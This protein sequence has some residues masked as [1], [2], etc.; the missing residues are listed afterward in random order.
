MNTNQNV[1][2]ASAVSR[3]PIS[4]STQEVCCPHYARGSEKAQAAKGFLFSSLTSNWPWAIIRTSS[5]LFFWNVH[6]AYVIW[7]QY[8]GAQR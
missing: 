7:F 2:I 1:P 3:L 5:F 8:V 6:V 4:A